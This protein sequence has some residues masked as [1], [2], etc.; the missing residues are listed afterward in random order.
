MLQIRPPAVAGA[1]YPDSPDIL[2]RDVQDYLGQAISSG[3]PPKALIA[4]HAG[5]IYSGP[6]AGFAYRLWQGSG[7]ER[8]IIL[9]PA[10]RVPVMGLALPEAE[11]FGTPLGAVPVDLDA[12]SGIEAMPQVI[13]N[14]AAHTLEH[15]VEVQVPFLQSVLEAFSIV[16]LVVGMVEPQKVAEVLEALWGDEKSGIVISSDL[17]HYHS[18]DVARQIDRETCEQIV[19]LDNTISHEQACGATGINGLLSVAKA[20]GMRMKLLD[21]RNSGDT[22]GPKG[23]VVGYGAFA[24]YE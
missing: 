7:I 10:H 9:G 15:S 3:P 21:M 18:Y 11:A 4:P 13:L 1:F 12:C 22:A 8:V 17:S 24:C 6:T 14:R 20:R 16:P 5:Y 19:A 23:Q 2:R